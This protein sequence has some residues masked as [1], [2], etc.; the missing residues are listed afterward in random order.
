WHYRSRYESLISFSNTAFY[1]GNLYTIP[2]RIRQGEAAE[3]IL[4]RQSEDAIRYAGLLLNRPI[5]FHLMERS[6]YQMRR[7]AGEA[8]YIAHLV[9]ELL[10]RET[11]L[12]I[13]IVAF[14]EAQQSEIESALAT[15]AEKDR[16]F[17][18]RLE[19]EY[20]RE[21]DDQYCGLFIKNLEN[22]QGD[23]RDIIIL[24]ICYGPDENGRMVMNFGPVNQRGGEKRL[25][26]IFSRA[27]QHMAIVSSIKHSAITNDYNDGAA[28]LKNFLH[29]AQSSSEGQPEVARSILDRLNPQ[30]A[31]GRWRLTKDQVSSELADALRARGYFVGEKI[32][33]SRFRCDIGIANPEEN[34]FR[35]GI[36]V[37]SENHYLNPDVMERFV[38]QPEILRAFGWKVTIVLTRDWF[39]NRD[40]IVERIERMM[41]DET[42]VDA[43]LEDAPNGELPSPVKTPEVKHRAVGT[44]QSAA[45]AI[46]VVPPRDDAFRRFELKEGNTMKFWEI[47]LAN[48]SVSVRFGKIGTSGQTRTTLFDSPERAAKECEKL[49][50]EKLRKGFTEVTP[51]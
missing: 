20:A 40:Q 15:L 36:I 39:Y 18:V 5:S 34:Y 38:T 26:V 25:N 24:S 12:S 11:K 1:A 3:Q 13:G 17:S 30:T 47:A 48:N 2:D 31:A 37:D 28:A 16:D 50:N 33:Q 21:E 35:V 23:E 29:Y 42:Q 43:E 49:V 44:E 10:T 6:P 41:N 9:R 22:V 27:R 19:Q 8:N 14:S 45:A 46:G 7:N 4:V 32:G 51:R